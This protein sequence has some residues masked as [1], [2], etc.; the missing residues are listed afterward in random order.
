MSRPASL[1]LGP[2][3]PSPHDELARL[4]ADLDESRNIVNGAQALAR[5]LSQQADGSADFAQSLPDALLE[6]LARAQDR[7]PR[8]ERRISA[9]QLQLGA[10]PRRAG[11]AAG[12]LTRRDLLAAAGLPVPFSPAQPP[13]SAVANGFTAP[14]PSSSGSRSADRHSPAFP[15]SGAGDSHLLTAQALTDSCPAAPAQPTE[16]QL[17]FDR[18]MTL[19]ECLGETDDVGE[20]V[21]AMDGIV[22][23]IEQFPSLK[24][25]VSLEEY[26]PSVMACL[27]DSAGKDVRAAT[28]RL[29]R[30]FLVD[31]SDALRLNE[32]HLP[33]LL[34]RSLA[35]DAKHDHEKT[36]ALRLV[37][38]LLALA[39]STLGHG[40]DIVP[41]SV[42]RGVVALAETPEEALRLA[43]LETLG[44]L[45]IRNLPLLVACEGLRVVLQALADGPFDLA[46]FLALAFLAA[47][48]HPE[49]RQ[50]L[51]PGVDVEVILAGFTEVHGKGS[52]VEERVKA[53]AGLVATFLQSWSGLFYLNIHGR[54]A[55]TSLVDSL[56]NPSQV[57]RETLLDMLF[58]VFNV[59]S[60]APRVSAV[61]TAVGASQRR[62]NLIDQF[63]AVLLLIFVEAGLIEALA[64]LAADPKDPSTASKVSLLIGEILTLANRVLPASH[65]VRVQSLPT[66]FALTAG[67]DPSRERLA[68]SEALL[69]VGRFERERE[70]RVAG[71]SAQ[72]NLRAR[73]NSLEDPHQRASASISTVRLAA[74]LSMDDLAFRNLLLESGVLSV[75]GE[76]RW[77]FDALLTLVQGPLRN[78]RRLEEATRATKFMRRVLAFYHPFAL[79]FSDLPKDPL[80]DKWVDLGCELVS[81]LVSSPV[82]AQYLAEDKLLPQLAEALFQLD[83]AS[84]V[85]ILLTKDRI[86]GTLASGYFAMLGVL[87]RS[88]EGKGLLDQ[89]KLWTAFYRVAEMRNREDLVR[90][91]I[92]SVD[93]STDGHARV[94]LS[95]ALTSSYKHI[96]LFATQ[97]LSKLLAASLAPAPWQIQLLVQQLYDSAPEVVSLAI[98]ILS[99]A[100][101]SLDVLRAVVALRPALEVLP[102]H[103]GEPLLTLFLADSEGVRYL[104]EI[105]WI[106]R[107]LETWYQERNLVYMVELE[108]A[109]AAALKT[110][111]GVQTSATPFDGTPPRHFYGELARTAEGCDI[112]RDSDRMEDF[113]DV[114]QMH[115]ESALERGYIV[116]LKSVLWAIG[117]VGSSSSGL[118][119]L[120][121]YDVLTDLVQIAAFS[122]VYSLRGT[123]T[124]ALALISSTEE[125]AEMLDELGWESVITPLRGPTG[126]CVPMYLNDYIYTPMW[127]PPLLDL[128]GT[129]DFSPATSTLER[130]ALTALAN[131]SNHILAT[132]ASRTLARLK[133]RHRTLFASPA[134]YARASEMLASHHYR[135]AVR[136]YVIELFEVE[137]SPRMAEQVADAA[138]TL[139]TRAR[140][141]AERGDGSEMQTPQFPPSSLPGGSP[142]LD[143]GPWAMSGA[144]AVGGVSSLLGSFA[145]NGRAGPGAEVESDDDDDESSEGG[146]ETTLPVKDLS[147]VVTVRGFLL[148]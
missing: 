51:R 74:A 80:T 92:Q 13:L 81:T 46:P 144:G 48:D 145:G 12:M 43:A 107:E 114:V 54:Q 23:S 123:A 130:E 136:K 82:G 141:R 62:T 41:V 133:A 134:L 76:N 140:R 33:L 90:V 52:S 11:P 138:E 72:D 117:H 102:D 79:R 75:K 87:S 103:E 28:Y 116:E 37:R 45:V 112:L 111:G 143:A 63:M 19:L 17:A 4:R 126:I 7:I 93:Y 30:H 15:P 125:G 124:Y 105:G 50:W 95:K 84:G 78:P 142:G 27:S 101:A 99:A 129:F 22:E 65:A 146:V 57:I 58:D 97:H 91:V 55:L 36:H 64:S 32:Q 115:E 128:P 147:P 86:E 89:F 8:L 60:T 42:L 1:R 3:Q 148:A 39:G 109:L 67:F 96:R 120:D 31:A 113:V 20:R 71:A 34:V 49:T 131:L 73:A 139:R 40:R 35:R 9:L 38:A 68:A 118:A 56:T 24:L 61:G 5:V 132:K 106:E 122:P 14:T 135:F 44:E 83:T 59:R 137:L 85:P 110:D 26:L 121:E 119:V 29:L 18:V 16:A 98:S 108:L 127:D 25:E 104:Q 47:V 21:R 77:D 88:E 2:P 94:F 70:Q 69:K 66:L 53:S 100:C 10:A 6:E